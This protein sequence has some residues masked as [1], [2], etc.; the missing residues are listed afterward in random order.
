MSCPA[1]GQYL[2]DVGWVWHKESWW[3]LGGKRRESNWGILAETFTNSH[4]MVPMMRI[5][6]NILQGLT[7]NYINNKPRSE[8]CG[9]FQITSNV[10]VM[11][12]TQLDL[13]VSP[14]SSLCFVI[15]FFIFV[16]L[17]SL[18]DWSPLHR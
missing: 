6:P 3:H 18:D 2:S 1:E 8:C 10:V 4:P 7:L 15:A 17:P 9:V 13:K 5:N 11:G 14:S 12:K 16:P